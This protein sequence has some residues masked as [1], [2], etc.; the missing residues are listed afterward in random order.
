LRVGGCWWVLPVS[1]DVVLSE[2]VSR[3]QKIRPTAVVP[4]HAFYKVI[5]KEQHA[6]ICFVGNGLAGPIKGVMGPDP[7]LLLLL[8]FWYT[9]DPARCGLKL[10]REYVVDAAALG[11]GLFICIDACT[12][13][14]EFMN[15]LV[16]R[17]PKRVQVSH[18]GLVA[19]VA[20]PPAGHHAHVEVV[21][22]SSFFTE[23]DR[24]HPVCVGVCG[25][26][27]II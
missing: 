4:S 23:G 5:A 12:T 10:I 22:V 17:R 24:A 21:F 3:R 19:E 1:V 26:G 9:L 2:V 16:A 15:V 13:S 8:G 7:E 6:T 27:V 11:N 18:A 14:I 20:P 25:F